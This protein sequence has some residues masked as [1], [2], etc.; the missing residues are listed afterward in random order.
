MEDIERARHLLNDMQNQHRIL[1]QK[2]VELQHEI[3]EYGI[4]IQQVNA[5]INFLISERESV[6]QNVLEME[7]RI[8]QVDHDIV[9]ARRTYD[10]LADDK[11]Q[12]L[13]EKHKMDEDVKIV[14]KEYENNEIHTNQVREQIQ[15][16]RSEYDETETL[17]TSMDQQYRQREKE[18]SKLRNQIKK[19]DSYATRVSQTIM[20]NKP[21]KMNYDE[22]ERSLRMAQSVASRVSSRPPSPIL[23]MMTH[24]RK[25][26][27]Q[28]NQSQ[29]SQIARKPSPALSLGSQN[30]KR[31]QSPA[32]GRAKRSQ[33]QDNSLVNLPSYSTPDN[34]SRTQ[35]SF[36]S[37][38]SSHH[39][40]PI[41]STKN[42]TSQQTRTPII[43]QGDY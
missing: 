43:A 1:E 7:T 32:G 4:V 24:T 37:V 5:R 19:Y 22:A 23:M 18:L 26:Y 20:M 34:I 8:K 16:T 39:A 42:F 15:I 38:R 10:K 12:L 31:S 40:K 29:S 14:A 27:D 3:R 33:S 6:H 35:T 41:S 30:L 36:T 13:S 28:F 2:K 11:S 25:S 9:R 21:S 17:K